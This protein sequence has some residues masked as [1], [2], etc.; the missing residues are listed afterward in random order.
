MTVGDCNDNMTV[1]FKAE[2]TLSFFILILFFI[3][4]CDERTLI[5]VMVKDDSSGG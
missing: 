3:Q 2:E 4:N 1:T 5:L